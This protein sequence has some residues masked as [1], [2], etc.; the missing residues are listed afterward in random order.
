MIRLVRSSL[1]GG[2]LL[3]VGALAMVGCGA[4]TAVDDELETAE[5]GLEHD[6]GEHAGK[7]HRGG[8]GRMVVNTALEELELTADQRT[9][10]EGLFQKDKPSEAER[11]DHAARAQALANAVRA[12]SID[13][14]TFAKKDGG[15]PDKRARFAADLDELHGI[16]SSDQRSE[17]VAA[18]KERAPKGPPD[19]EGRHGPDGERRGKGPKGEGRRGPGGPMGF[20]LHGIDLSDSQKETIQKALTDAGIGPKEGKEGKGKPDHAAMKAKIEAAMDAF[21]K[22]DFKAADVLPEPPEGAGGPHKMIEALAI[23]VPHL[24]AEQRAELADRIEEGP[25]RGGPKGKRGRAP[26]E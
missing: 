17:L 9:K 19:G 14:A 10:I 16:L 25:M 3:V 20:M 15:R 6:A 22:D 8:P 21:I 4:T 13:V 1:V 11:E 26:Q 18:L 2:A 24:T 7:H 23:A 12:G 5:A